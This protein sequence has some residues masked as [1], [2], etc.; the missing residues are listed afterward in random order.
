MVNLDFIESKKW[1]KFSSIVTLGATVAILILTGM[2]YSTTDEMTKATKEIS[3]FTEQ[4]LKIEEESKALELASI[5]SQYAGFTADLDYLFFSIDKNPNRIQIKNN[6]QTETYLKHRLYFEVYCDNNG[7]AHS[8]DGEKKLLIDDE[9]I[10]IKYED[11]D[12][13]E[14]YLP[15]DFLDSTVESFGLRFT[16]VAHPNLS[17]GF[18]ESASD[19]KVAHLQY[20]LT[21]EGTRWQPSI[22]SSDGGFECGRVPYGGDQVRLEYTD[23]DEFLEC[24]TC[25]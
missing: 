21:E 23:E 19:N 11:R 16:V 9:E 24:S 8:V 12:S 2:L 4:S 1:W 10:V 18:I 20:V 25:K 6:I 14:F 17:I 15:E 5:E 13:L 22:V 3:K 7:V